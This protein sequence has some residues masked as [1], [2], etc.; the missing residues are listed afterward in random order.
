M[1]IA[2]FIVGFYKL[3]F[4]G[5]IA[6]CYLQ[7][8]IIAIAFWYLIKAIILCLD[9]RGLKLDRYQFKIYCKVKYLITINI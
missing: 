3:P 7:L 1:L 6:F 4:V 2:K 8:I 5:N 9:K